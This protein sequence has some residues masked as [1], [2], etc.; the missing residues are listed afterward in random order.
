MRALLSLRFFATIAAILPLTALAGPSTSGG[1]FAVV[2]RNSTGVIESA[3]ILDLFEARTVHKFELMKSSGDELRDYVRAVSNGY[4]LQGYNPPISDQEMIDNVEKFRKI[5]TW[6]PE[7]EKLPNLD[8]LGLSIS[9][10]VGCKIEPLAIFYDNQNIVVIDKAIWTAMDSLS[11]SALVLHEIYYH[12]FRQ[13]EIDPDVNSI[14]ARLITASDCRFDSRGFS[15]C[16]PN[17]SC[18]ESTTYHDFCN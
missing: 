8:D 13:L 4:R 14:E 18:S 10:P 17:E 7:D 5:M 2:C 15:N 12:A 3:E 1:G 9:V 6:L 16:Q 11:Q